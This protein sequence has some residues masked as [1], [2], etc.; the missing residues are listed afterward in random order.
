MDQ[1]KEI[2]SERDQDR[3]YKKQALV[4][5]EKY[6]NMRSSLGFTLGNAGA[7]L[8]SG[9]FEG[10]Q[11]KPA[12]YGTNKNQVAQSSAE[13]SIYDDTGRGKQTQK[14]HRLLDQ[15][16]RVMAHESKK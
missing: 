5:K 15:A 2:R 8:V 16:K 13:A 14:V 12:S 4:A 1:L 9:G 6:G 3:T 7:S 10:S 11:Q